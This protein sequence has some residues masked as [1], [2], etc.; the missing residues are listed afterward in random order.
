MLKLFRT[1]LPKK[2]DRVKNPGHVLTEN[3]NEIALALKS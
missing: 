1:N 2:E 3:K